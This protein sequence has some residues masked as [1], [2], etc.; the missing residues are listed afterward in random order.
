VLCVCVCV[1][2]EPRLHAT[3]VSA[4]KVNALYPVLSS[5]YDVFVQ[6]T[7]VESYEYNGVTYRVGDFVY[8]EQ[9]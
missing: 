3:L 2:A 7:S 8:V 6:E 4:A 1:S 9:R 5:L